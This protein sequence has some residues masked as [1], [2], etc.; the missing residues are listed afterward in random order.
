MLQEVMITDL[1]RMQGDKVCIACLNRQWETIRP[2]LPPPGILERDLYKQGRAIIR[3]GAVVKM[4]LEA[5]SSR[6]PPHVED[7]HWHKPKTAEFVR[8]VPEQVWKNALVRLLKPSIKAIFETEIYDGRALKPG[9]GVRSLGTVRPQNEISF[10]YRASPYRKKYDCKLSFMDSTGE[11]FHDLPVTDLTLRCYADYLRVNEQM[12]ETQ[13]E[14]QINE[15]LR[16]REIYLR[17]GVGRPFQKTPTDESWCYLQVNG[18]YTFPDFLGGK[19]F[20][21]FQMMGFRVE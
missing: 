4:D 9:T 6:Q 13:V 20:A 11:V 17:I 16:Q 8:L 19:C 12:D 18:V 3:P 5:D 10:R 7:H 21:D 2:N 14:T 15:A 1:T